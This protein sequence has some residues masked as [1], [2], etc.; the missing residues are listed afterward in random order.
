MRLRG[1]SGRRRER[2]LGVEVVVVVR[3][4]GGVDE[5]ELF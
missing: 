4:E 2:G 1:R 3:V 5:H